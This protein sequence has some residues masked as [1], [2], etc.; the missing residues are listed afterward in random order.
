MPSNTKRFYGMYSN[1]NSCL[2]L[3]QIVSMQALYYSGLSIFYIFLNFTF[4]LP[5]HFGQYFHYSSFNTDH[6]YGVIAI[7]AVFMNIPIVIT[8]LI[9]IVVKANKVLDFVSTIYFIHFVI[10]LFYNRFTFFSI[11]WIFINAVCYLVTVVVGEYVCIKFEQ[12][13]IKFLENILSFVNKEMSPSKA[14]GKKKKEITIS[15]TSTTEIE[16]N[17][18]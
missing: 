1:F 15:D 18:V 17:E 7:T 5:L 11:G 12:Q 6:Y 4:G 8:G 2:I 3:L 10:C 9:Y 13:E 16:L 14:K